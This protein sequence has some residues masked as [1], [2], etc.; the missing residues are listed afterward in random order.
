[1]RPAILATALALFL[2][3]SPATA[4]L[5]LRQSV[6]FDPARVRLEPGAAV[7]HAVV[8]GLPQLPAEGITFELACRISWSRGDVV[9]CTAVDDS[10]AARAAITI[11]HTY[12][13]DMSGIEKASEGP[14]ADMVIPVRLSEADRRSLGFLTQPPTELS[15]ITFARTPGAD[16]MTPY[17]PAAALRANV[18]T[19]VTMTC[20]VQADLSA[21]CARPAIEST[22]MDPSMASRFALAALQIT[23]FFRVGPTLSD[24]RSSV[25]VVFNYD[26]HFRLPDPN[27]ATSRL[28]RAA[29]KPI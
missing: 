19:G 3:A 29:A 7:R 5:P 17:Y 20:Q 4:Q 12:V 24:G 28:P 11:A 6:N 26:I 18:Q 15:L 25:G 2:H 10:P 23:S 21:F 16:M 1:M 22:G 14:L 9:G 8:A 13:F 27:Q